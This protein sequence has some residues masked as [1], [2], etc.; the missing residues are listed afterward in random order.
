MLRTL[1]SQFTQ[2][3]LFDVCPPFQIDGNYGGSA[4][5]AEML[6]QS[7]PGVLDLLP[8]LPAAWSE[9]EVRGLRARGGFK[10]DLDWRHGRLTDY[11]VHSATVRQVSINY[12]GTSRRV[13]LKAGSNRYSV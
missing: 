5:I 1:I 2:P 11:A 9:G 6:L 13:T 7:R 8:A 3:N 12:G 10:V 4:G